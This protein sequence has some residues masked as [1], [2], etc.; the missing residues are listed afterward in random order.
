MY[1]STV[2]CWSTR[3]PAVYPLPMLTAKSVVCNLSQLISFFGIPKIITC[4]HRFKTA[5]HQTQPVLRVSC[6]KSWGSKTFPS[7]IKILLAYCVEMNADWEDGLP[8]LLAAKGATQKSTGFSP[9]E[10]VFGH[11]VHGRLVALQND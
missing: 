5:V 4:L 1:L 10:L 11:T 6:A 9:S 2:V 8:L 3:Y 7:D